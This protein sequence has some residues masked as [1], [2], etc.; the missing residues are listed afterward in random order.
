MFGKERELVACYRTFPPVGPCWQEG[1]CPHGFLGRDYRGRRRGTASETTS[2]VFSLSRG[3][4]GGLRGISGMVPCCAA[5]P[6][7]R[8]E[9]SDIPPE[10][11]PSEERHAQRMARARKRERS[12]AQR[13]RSEHGEYPPLAQA[14]MVLD[15]QSGPGRRGRGVLSTGLFRARGYRDFNP[16]RESNT[17]GRYRCIRGALQMYTGGRYRCIHPPPAY[18]QD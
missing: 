6:L 4:S 12:H 2:A 3:I 13:R 10:P 17:G 16:Y 5:I 11:T 7:V 9:P 1:G 14:S 18:P 8:R 15:S